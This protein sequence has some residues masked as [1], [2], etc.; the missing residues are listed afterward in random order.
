MPRHGKQYRAVKAD[1]EH[2]GYSVEEAAVL[3]KDR[4]FAK[5]DETVEMA[6]NLGVDP[7]HADQ[8]VRSSVVLPHGTGK[9]KRV[10][11]IA[12]G[13]KLKE[14]EEAGADFVGGSDL[15]QKIGDGW[16]DFEAV[17][18]T[19][20]M[21]RD[22][23]KLGRILGPRGLMPNPK[24]GTVTFDVAKAVDEIKGGKLDFRVD[25]HG[26][27]HVSVGKVSFE[28]EA[29]TENMKTFLEAVLRARPAAAKGKYIK[30]IYVTTTMGPSIQLD[31]SEA[32]L[33]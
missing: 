21:M 29:I 7:R 15:V 23:G 2:R 19:P 8:M 25:K 10:V 1:V 33:Q 3:L 13:E 27:V 20:D 18:A 32:S 6:L 28:A 5:F 22:V 24:T 30:N 17:V 14:A 26:I 4:S 31:V 12:Q 16:L 9:V 11:V